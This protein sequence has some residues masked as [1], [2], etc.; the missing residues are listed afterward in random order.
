MKQSHSAVK[1]ENFY[2]TKVIVLMHQ[3]LEHEVDVFGSDVRGIL[4]ER[5]LHC[6]S[7]KMDVFVFIMNL[8]YF[9]G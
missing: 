3:N 7:G 9:L 8:C 4:L 6:I 1:N 5:G 2:A